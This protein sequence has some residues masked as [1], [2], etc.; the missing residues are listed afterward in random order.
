MGK[1]ISPW[2]D[3]GRRRKPGAKHDD[4]H[5]SQGAFMQPIGHDRPDVRADLAL[6]GAAAKAADYPDLTVLGFPSRDFGFGFRQIP[7]SSKV[8]T[9]KWSPQG[10]REHDGNRPLR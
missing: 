8:R 10:H 4:R 5:P 6:S 9:P 7:Q 1:T 2:I 3:D